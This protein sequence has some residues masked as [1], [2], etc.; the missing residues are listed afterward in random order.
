[1][2]AAYAKTNA[3][4]ASFPSAIPNE[5]TEIKFLSTRE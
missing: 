4:Y 3:N 5:Y 1:L 2:Q